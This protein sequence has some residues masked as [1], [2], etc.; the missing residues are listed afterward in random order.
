MDISCDYTITGKD[1][2]PAL[3][4]IG[5]ERYLRRRGATGGKT[6]DAT[7]LRWQLWV[8]VGYY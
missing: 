1:A 6:A 8:I 2:S 7:Q 4:Y 5:T 3:G